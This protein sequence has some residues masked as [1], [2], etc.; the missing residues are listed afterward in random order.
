[1]PSV[2]HP[3]NRLLQAA[4]AAELEALRPHLELVDLVRE[5]VL[6][7]AG[8]PLTDVYLPYSGV[9]S[10]RVRLSQGQTVDV[11]MIGCDSVSAPLPR[12][13]ARYR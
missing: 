11:A 5:A 9:L 13:A 7:E 3:P 12:S 8:A 2:L 1:M 10:V 4:P 6:I